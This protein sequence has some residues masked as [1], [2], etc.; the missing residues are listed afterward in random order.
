MSYFVD[1]P[2]KTQ[3]N[4]ERR[5]VGDPDEPLCTE[6]LHDMKL[7]RKAVTYRPLTC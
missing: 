1:S 6:G 7:W 3:G 2:R 4:L 5:Y